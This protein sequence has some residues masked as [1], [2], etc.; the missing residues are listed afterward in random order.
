MECRSVPDTYD[1]GEAIRVG[2]ASSRN[3]F[4]KRSTKVV[5]AG[6]WFNRDEFVAVGP[7]ELILQVPLIDCFTLL[8]EIR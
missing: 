1:V 2:S 4:T 6:N 3:G 7:F 8:R 5:V